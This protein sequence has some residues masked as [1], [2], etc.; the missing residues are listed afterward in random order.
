VKGWRTLWLG[1]LMMGVWFAWRSE[2][3]HD[4]IEHL[5]AAWLMS[6]GQLP[7]RDFL[8]QH[9]PVLWILFQPLVARL[10]SPDHLVFVARLYDLALIASVAWTLHRLVRRL[11]TEAEAAPW[12][13]LLVLGSY[14]F[15][16]N[17]LLFRPDP[18]MNAL[19]YAGLLQWAVFL[20]E[21]R[22]RRA[23]AAGLLFGLAV[24]VLQKALVVCGL[25]GVAWLGILFQ[26]RQDP[27]RRSLLLGA[28]AALGTALLPLG[29]LAG[30]VVAQG[31]WREFWLWNYQ[32]NGFFYTTSSAG[33][34]SA[35]GA[36]YWRSLIES[37]ALWIGGAVGAWRWLRRPKSWQPDDDV[38]LT[39][40][41]TL[42]G[43]ILILSF[44][45]LPFEQYLIV[46]LPLWA[47]F[48]AEMAH[49]P[50]LRLGALAGLLVALGQFLNLA[51]NSAERRVQAWLLDHTSPDEPLY[52]AP[53]YHPIFR[54]DATYL[55]YNGVLIG[56]AA[57]EYQKL[58]PGIMAPHGF[59]SRARFVY[60]DP[61][62]PHGH[63]WRW[64]QDRYRP[65]GEPD[66]WMKK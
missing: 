22:V 28:A 39:L 66:I 54:R 56:D 51:D 17:M 18:T 37:P 15:S 30:W 47:L 29:A 43:Y 52:A 55:W 4:E 16:H 1:L 45:K 42:L 57:A 2:Y 14:I 6:I 31:I 19:F 50:W 58:H 62:S 23:A 5:H 65:S 26:H 20:Q 41:V 59:D 44:N 48:A 40:L 53:P 32:F 13:V 9:H 61:R 34:G 63:P 49:T 10:H 33:I 7:Y 25:V 27:R 11:H 3:N 12:A 36:R 38:R 60:L 21:G 64:P 46:F 8:E 24:A 35:V